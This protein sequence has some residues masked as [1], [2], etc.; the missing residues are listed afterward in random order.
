LNNTLGGMMDDDDDF[1]G[2]NND[3]RFTN[4]RELGRVLDLVET[5]DFRIRSIR[6]IVDETAFQEMVLR[7]VP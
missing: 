2:G 7:L 4:G 1:V 5:D 6:L 3:G